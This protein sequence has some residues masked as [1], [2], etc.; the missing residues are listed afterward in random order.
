LPQPDGRLLFGFN[1][2]LYL[3]KTGWV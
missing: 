2:T 3:N 1:Q